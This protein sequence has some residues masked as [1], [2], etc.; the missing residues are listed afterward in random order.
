[1]SVGIDK[2]NSSN[3]K[4]WNPKWSGIRDSVDTCVTHWEVS[5]FETLSYTKLSKIRI[6][7]AF[8]VRCWG[9]S[10]VDKTLAMQTWRSEFKFLEPQCKASLSTHVG[11]WEVE[12]GQSLWA[13][14]PAGL[15]DNAEKQWKTRIAYPVGRSFVL[16][17]D[18][19][20]FM[21]AWGIF[22]HQLFLSC[23]PL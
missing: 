7:I 4:L 21:P 23:V 19:L 12:T 16:S 15:G 8:L 13:H 1:M 17:R 2:L 6:P 3:P 11:K 14:E 10:S 9:D 22:I 18:M 5:H 20:G